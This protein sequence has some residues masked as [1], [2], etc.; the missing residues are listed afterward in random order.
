MKKMLTTMVILLLVAC[1]V[2]SKNPFVNDVNS[3]RPRLIVHNNYWD[4]KKVV[5]YCDNARIHSF[6]G[7]TFSVDYVRRLNQCFDQYRFVVNNMWDSG[8]IIWTGGDI[9]LNLNSTLTM[10]SVYISR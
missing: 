4:T 8:Y 5:V 2:S 6:R 10:S 1:A 9:I 7:F 3:N